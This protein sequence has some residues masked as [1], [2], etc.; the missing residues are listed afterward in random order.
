MLLGLEEILGPSPLFAS[1]TTQ[2]LKCISRFSLLILL[3]SKYP[4]HG[5]KDSKRRYIR[6]IKI[7]ILD[8]VHLSPKENMPSLMFHPKP[9]SGLTTR[10]KYYSLEYTTCGWPEEHITS[11]FQCK[12]A[13]TNSE[14]FGFYVYYEFW[15]GDHAKHNPIIYIQFLSHPCEQVLWAFATEDCKMIMLVHG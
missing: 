12:H 9:V 10:T 7:L 6:T 4:W 2:C 8:K 15:V 3:L 11:I 13:N 1:A 14:E 5:K